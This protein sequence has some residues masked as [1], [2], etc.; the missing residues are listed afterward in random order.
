[1]GVRFDVWTS[2]QTLRDE[3]RVSTALQ[4]LR[5]R[6]AIDERHGAQWLRTS[7]F[8]DTEDHPVVRSNGQPTY[9][10][11]DIA[12]HVFK[13]ERGFD[14]LIN[15]WTAEHRQYVERTRAALRALNCDADKVEI[16]ACEGARWLREGVPVRRGAASETFTLDEALRA[17]GR[18][19]L[20]FLILRRDCNRSI[21]IEWESARRDDESNAAYAARLLPSRL[22]TMIGETEAR[23]AQAK[24]E[25]SFEYSNNW[26]ASACNEAEGALARLVALWPDTAQ[27]AALERA[28]HHLTD[29]VGELVLST[30]EVLKNSRPN[31]EPKQLQARLKV[32]Q[33]ASVVAANVLRA[34]GLDANVKF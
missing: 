14:R 23:V 18:D 26:S 16:I 32:L 6:G 12:Y 33:A 25:A 7:A 24:T 5:E 1:M 21:D 34:L 13:M 20:R 4:K 22:Q 28:P 2:E 30:R 9:L 29:F 17:V 8:G 15:I 27:S 31:D 11:T 10:A 19:T 3:G